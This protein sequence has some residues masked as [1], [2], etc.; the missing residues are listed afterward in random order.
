MYG[1]DTCSCAFTPCCQCTVC[2][3]S[4]TVKYLILRKICFNLTLSAFPMSFHRRNPTLTFHTPRN[5]YPLKQKKRKRQLE[6]HRDHSSVANCWT[7]IPVILKGIF[8]ILHG[9]SER[10]SIYSSISHR[11]HRFN[12]TLIPRNPGW[13]TLDS[14]FNLIYVNIH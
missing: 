2:N 11:M 5:A 4:E 3:S 8:G 6:A 1:T 13:E 10:L 7:K 9:I 12:R 14:S